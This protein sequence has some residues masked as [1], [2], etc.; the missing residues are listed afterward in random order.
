MIENINKYR[1]H[2]SHGIPVFTLITVSYALVCLWMLI[3]YAK[4]ASW[5][6]PLFLLLWEKESD[7]VLFMEAQLLPVAL[8]Q[9][10]LS[11]VIDFPLRMLT[12]Y[13]NRSVVF[14]LTLVGEFLNLLLMLL[15]AVIT[16]LPVVVL[17]IVAVRASHGIRARIIGAGKIAE[18]ILSLKRF[19]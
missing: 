9:A 18:K 12:D 10:M 1:P 6:I 5:I 15:S 3:P 4:Y 19:Q 8:A 17:I 16:V 7:F 11:A 13:L 14:G 2:T